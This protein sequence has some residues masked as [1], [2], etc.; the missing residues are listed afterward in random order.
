MSIGHL[1]NVVEFNLGDTSVK[2]RTRKYDE[3]CE[4]RIQK[5]IYNISHYYYFFVTFLFQ[6]FRISDKIVRKIHLATQQSF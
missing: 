1:L 2:A 4:H 6:Y 5:K 3:F